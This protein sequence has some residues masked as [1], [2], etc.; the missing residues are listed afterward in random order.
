MNPAEIHDALADITDAPLYPIEIPFAFAQA[1]DAAKAE[2]SKLRTGTTS[3]SDLPS[4][5]LF[6]KKFHYAPALTGMV[7]VTLEQ[8]RS[9]KKTKTAKPAT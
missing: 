4:G 1:T 2:I 6:N 5:V 7:E 8:L 9:S 3:K